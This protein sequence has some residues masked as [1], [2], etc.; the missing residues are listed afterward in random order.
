M[1]TPVFAETRSPLS[2]KPP[3]RLRSSRRGL[4]RYIFFIPSH[5]CIPTSLRNK[6]LQDL[7]KVSHTTAQTERERERERE[8]D[9]Q[10]EVEIVRDMVSRAMQGRS[11]G[12]STD[13]FEGAREETR[14]KAALH[15]ITALV[16]VSP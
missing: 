12:A 7:E 14:T 1:N 16:C 5:I 2:I 8:I 3:F 9:R 15:E 10:T 11:L 13:G 6:D 4:A